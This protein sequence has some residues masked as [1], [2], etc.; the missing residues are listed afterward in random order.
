V[1]SIRIRRLVLANGDEYEDVD[2]DAD[3]ER[4]E[5]AMMNGLP[6]RMTWAGREIHVNASFIV[7][8]ERE[9]RLMRAVK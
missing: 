4:L 6:V 2:I 9:V 7:S 8:M 1:S 5:N 3:H